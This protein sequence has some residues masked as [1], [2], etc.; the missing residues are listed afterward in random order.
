MVAPTELARRT[1]IGASLVDGAVL[2]ALSMRLAMR[3]N[4]SAAIR[5]GK[6]NRVIDEVLVELD[7]RIGLNGEHCVKSI[8]KG[9]RTLLWGASEKNDLP[10]VTRYLS[11]K[12]VTD[13]RLLKLIELAIKVSLY[14]LG[15][16]ESYAMN[17]GTL[18][19]ARDCPEILGELAGHLGHELKS[20]DYRRLSE[21]LKKIDLGWPD[22]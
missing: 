17:L 6:D 14:N 4:L 12:E 20:K 11:L 9:A 3:E 13:G 18:Q 7:E 16:E 10:N 1:E 2:V 22:W 15:D 8:I 21:V 5:L 19:L